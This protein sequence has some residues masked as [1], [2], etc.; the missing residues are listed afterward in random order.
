MLV[1]GLCEWQTNINVQV[2]TQLILTL[3]LGTFQEQ[4]RLK[5]SKYLPTFRQHQTKN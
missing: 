5:A 4:L 1:E 3:Y 2:Y